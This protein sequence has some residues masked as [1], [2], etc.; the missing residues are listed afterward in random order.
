MRV[1]ALAA[2]IVAVLAGCAPKR[3]YWGG[4]AQGVGEVQR[5]GQ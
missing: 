3:D 2:V 5:R 1:V 4:L